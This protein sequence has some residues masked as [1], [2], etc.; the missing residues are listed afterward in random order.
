M[1]SWSRQEKLE[2][3]PW[4][5]FLRLPLCIWTKNSMLRVRKRWMWQ[6]FI[7]SSQKDC[8]HSKCIV[9]YQATT[10]VCFTFKAEVDSKTSVVTRVCTVN[11][12]LVWLLF[13]LIFLLVTFKTLNTNWLNVLLNYR[14]PIFCVSQN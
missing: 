1:P 2:P 9:L 4:D 13:I 8:Y 6:D 11:S 12:Y 5:C 3:Y 14:I 10:V 7:K